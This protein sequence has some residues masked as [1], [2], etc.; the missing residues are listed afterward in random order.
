AANFVGPLGVAGALYPVKILFGMA[1][2]M[3]VF[4]EH[5]TELARPITWD[6]LFSLLRWPYKALIILSTLSFILNWRRVRVCDLLLWIVFLAFSLTALRNMTYFALIACFVTMRNI[7][8]IGLVRILPFTFRS[9][10]TFHVCGALLSLLVMFKLVDIG[11]GLAVAAYYDLDTY[12]EKKVFLGVAQR[13][14]PHKAADFLLMNRIGGNFFNDFNS[15][16]YLIGRLFPQV[17]V[18][19]D[20]RTE[21]RGSDFFINVYKKVWNDGDAAVFDRIVEE[22]G[23]TGA[24]INTATT[25]APESLL[26]MIAARKDWRLVYFDHDALIFLRDVPENRE[27][28]AQFGIDLDGWTPPQIDILKIG[29]RGVTPYHH[30]SRAL[31][32]KTLGYLDQAMAELD[33][34]VHVDPSYERAYRA[35]AEILKER[36]MFKEAFDNRRLSAIYSGKTVRRMADLADAYIDLNDLP[37][38]EDLIKELQ[39]AAPKDGRVRVVVAKDSFK[40]GADAAAYDILRAIMAEGKD[41]RPLLLDLADEFERLGQEERAREIRR[42]AGSKPVGK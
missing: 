23:L 35:R 25:S 32:L 2:D 29:A 41:P 36:Q 39:G 21:L 33:M 19:M 6:S 7:S 5:I 34:A 18:F 30:L 20:G 27:A 31:S 22:Y 8:G 16:A 9:E 1:G 42:I 26:K 40:K 37:A 14:F 12:Q 10:K 15:G 28:I 13:D 24:F 17:R 3:G 11:S 4:F 38:A